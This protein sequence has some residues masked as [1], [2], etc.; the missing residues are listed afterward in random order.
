MLPS[1]SKAYSGKCLL[2][3]EESDICCKELILVF[4]FNEAVINGN[5]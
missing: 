1:Q 3:Y 2:C 4:I 5:G